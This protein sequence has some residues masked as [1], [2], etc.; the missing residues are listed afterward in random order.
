ML[1]L[2]LLGEVEEELG[3]LLVRPLRFWP[4]LP[5]LQGAADIELWLSLGLRL[6]WDLRL[7]LELR[8]GCSKKNPTSLEPPFNKK[9]VK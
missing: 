3:L 7:P 1:L 6:P 5:T 9:R 2:L 8:S 4:S